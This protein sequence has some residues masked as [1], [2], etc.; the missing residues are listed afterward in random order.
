MRLG[1]DVSFSRKVVKF[2]RDMDKSGELKELRERYFGHVTRLA[3]VDVVGIL[4]RRGTLLPGLVEHFRAAQRETGID[5]RFL[6][7]VA[8]QESQWDTHAVSPTG[9]R[10][11]MM[12]TEDTADHLGVKD[13]LDA[14]ESILGGARYIA[15][16]RDALPSSVSE[17]DRP[18]FALAAYNL[19]RG[20]LEDAR[21]LA[22]RL[23][24]DP[25]KWADLKEVLPLLSRA[26]HNQ[27]LRHGF[28]RGGE[29][30]AMA[31]NVRIY[32]DILSRYEQPLRDIWSLD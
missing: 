20:H 5:W 28:A 21:T 23:G 1:A 8:Y 6:A 11:I 22:R 16:L 18:W 3:D 7:A 27:A 31:E 14:R 9:V 2:F 17:P 13:R 4:E 32:Y 30:R 15:Q 25:D 19:G 12:L 29:A 10:G 24:K 26:K